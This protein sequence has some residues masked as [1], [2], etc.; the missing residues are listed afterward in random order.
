MPLRVSVVVPVH[1]AEPY[2]PQTID[3]VL[4][5][6]LPASEWELILVDDGSTDGSGAIL[7]RYAREHAN[8]R[9]FTIPASGGPSAPRNRGLDEAH[10][11]FV[12]FLDSDDYFAPATLANLLARADATGSDIVLCRMEHAT[13][14]TRPIPRAV[15]A[16]ER[17]AEDFVESYAFRALGPTKLYRRSL[18]DDNGI[19]FPSGYFKGEDQAFTMSAYLAANHISAI[20]DRPYYFVRTLP[21]PQSASRR[22]QTPAQDLQKN[23]DHIGAIVHGT[24]PGPRRDLLLERPMIGPAGVTTVFRTAFADLDADDAEA[25]TER[26]RTETA[27]VWD[28]HLR[29]R[30]PDDVRVRLELLYAGRTADLQHA[31]RLIG[32]GEPLPLAVGRV[33][34]TY[35][36]PSGHEVDGLREVTTLEAIR[37]EGARLSLDV[38]LPPVTSPATIDDL[39]VVFTGVKGAGSITT[40][41]SGPVE[42]SSSSP[43]T[44]TVGVALDDLRENG[45]RRASGSLRIGDVTLRTPLAIAAAVTEHL[46]AAVDARAVVFSSTAAFFF[47]A[48]D[49]LALDIGPTTSHAV[50]GAATLTHA[51]RTPFGILVWARVP[52]VPRPSVRARAHADKGAAGRL[53]RWAPRRYAGLVPGRPDRKVSQITL[54]IG[55]Q[56]VVAARAD[57]RRA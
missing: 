37:L 28:E 20:S 29:E 16:K 19:R 33:G 42:L 21:Q 50:Q 8:I 18:L 4:S 45:I 25:L 43:T 31:A 24:E 32:A 3:S 55:A 46:P 52:F 36:S 39:A 38:A 11:E 35:R 15:F 9:H 10:G 47:T 7:A 40:T 2:L 17:R 53:F 34:F 14:I 1:N 5:Q 41:R 23:L 49:Q 6:T 48:V 12:F 26:A 44:V 13:E 56:R 30:A 54:M 22:G 27:H 57:A 51:V